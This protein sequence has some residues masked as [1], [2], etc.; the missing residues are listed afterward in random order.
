VP[1]LLL[2][3]AC[4]FGLPAQAQLAP[5]RLDQERAKDQRHHPE[6][7]EVRLDQVTSLGADRP[8]LALDPHL[9]IFVSDQDTVSQITFSEVMDQLVKQSGDAFLTKQI[10][11]AQWWDSAGQAPGLALGP[12]CDDESP[13]LPLAG[14]ATHSALSTRNNFP[15]RCPRLEVA[16]ATS[17]PFA[18]ESA[19]AGYGAIALSNRFDLHADAVDPKRKGHHLAPDCGE[20][21]IVFARNSGKTDPL[22]RNLVIFEARVPNP[23][24]NQ[25]VRGCRPILDFWHSLSD[26]SI[27]AVDRGKKLHD[28][29]LKGLPRHKVGPIVDIAHYT[30]GTGQIRSNQFMLN[31][32]SPP[33]PVDWTLR[34]FKTLAA[35]GTLTI[36][37]DS[38][39]TDPGNKLFESGSTDPRTGNISQDIRAQMGTLLGAAGPAKGPADI[40]SIGFA[41][42]GEGINAFESDERDN[43]LG[44]IAF[45]FLGGAS[46]PNP[47][48][49]ANIQGV[50]T[51]A[52]SSLTPTNIVKRVRTQTCAGC[53]RYSNGDTDLGG[54]AVWPDKES[55]A[56]PT[57]RPMPFTQESELPG[58]MQPAIVGNGKRYGISAAVEAFLVFR[59]AFMKKALGLP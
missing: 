4:L 51:Q 30:F 19:P 53:H 3:A 38:V 43:A 21:R 8:K 57:H 14:I 36:I 47:L 37:P 52:H 5:F 18:D 22:N 45:A 48:L 41:V 26:K 28:F 49:S 20:Y 33:K 17:D 24:K 6:R 9:S 34:E 23:D 25:E 7:G 42:T 29:Y 2:L 58:D 39:K 15:Y 56:D 1:G 40:N 50:L 11:F 16:E 44:D 27:S 32:G 55:S 54:G 59:E 31:A 13:A 46:T 35:N 12:H 10:L